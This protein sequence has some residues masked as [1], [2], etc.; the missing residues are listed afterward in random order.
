MHK[1]LFIVL[2][3]V[4]ISFSGFTGS[5]AFAISEDIIL[6]NDIVKATFNS[7][8]GSLIGLK[9][10]MSDWHIQ[11]RPELALSFEL[12]VPLPDRR[13]NPVLGKKQKVKKYTVSSDGNKVTFIW[14][15]LESEH[16][17]ILNIVFT[18]IVT[19]GNSGLTFEGEIENKSPYI[20]ETISYPFIG[21]LSRPSDDDYL[22]ASYGEIFMS[23]RS[24]FPNFSNSLGYWGTYHPTFGIDTPYGQYI[25]IN[26]GK[27]GLYVGYHDTTM[28]DMV[29]FNFVLKPGAETLWTRVPAKKE[30][31][32]KPV[33]VE[34]SSIYFIFVHSGETTNL[35]PVVLKPYVGSWH[36]GADYYKEWRK[37]WFKRPHTPD[38]VK[39]IHSWQ[40]LRLNTPEDDRGV[41]YKDLVKYGEDCSKHG[42]KA[43]Q[44]TGWNL[45]GQDGNDP[46]H[47][48]EPRLGTWEDLHDAI[49]KIQA[50]GVK[51]ILFTKFTWAD[52][53]TDWYREELI[54]HVAKDPYGNPHYYDGYM[55]QTTTQLADINTRRFAIMCHMD[56]EWRKIASEEFKKC[57]MLG[58]DGMLFDEV[59]HHGGA[60][61][62][63]YCFDPNHGHHVPAHLYEGD[64]KLARDF[65]KIADVYNKDFLFA[66]EHPWELE[67]GEYALG[68]TRFGGEGGDQLGHY[69]DPDRPVLA[70]VTGFDDREVINQCL[71]N[72]FNICYE[73]YHFKGRLDDF[74]LTLEYGKKVDA[75][76]RKYREYVWDAI[77]C[78]KLG[79][80]VK[81]DN[82]PYNGYSVFK[83]EE[84][85]KHAVVVF[86]HDTKNE[87]TVEITIENSSSSLVLATPEK[88][89]ARKTDGKVVIPPR[90]V[91][92]VMEK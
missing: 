33:H 68:Y 1:V 37:T 31:S 74:P 65:H 56:E 76:R 25:L 48:I 75:F 20:V 43:L 52:L 11:D 64:L 54:H 7:E 51:I 12:L 63:H 53:S 30:I 41:M 9:S 2:L 34:F 88:P 90:S 60:R 35:F 22:H 40:Q 69:V 28:R 10:K 87:K 38:W 5:E 72:R 16:G 81:S 27:E 18:G 36:K 57:L 24:I 59:Q 42:V 89:D 79:A 92:V 58:A 82:I 91:V 86:N 46:S 55:Y 78:E 17:G 32:G 50:M 19:I 49:E 4:I 80:S 3:A 14:D 84:S 8:T 13:D 85:G 29:R 67:Y 21:D 23:N 66:G 6:E 26:N 77:F 39:D 15:N 61:T 73:P 44:L 83:N 71:V 45:G 70:M 47:D 62:R